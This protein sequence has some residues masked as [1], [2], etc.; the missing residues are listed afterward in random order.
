[1]VFYSTSYVISF[2]GL[3]LCIYFISWVHNA[4]LRI[5]Q[6]MALKTPEFVSCCL[7]LVLPLFSFRAEISIFNGKISKFLPY[8]MAC[9]TVLL[10]LP[11]LKKISKIITQRRLWLNI[12]MTLGQTMKGKLS[13]TVP[14]YIAL[15]QWKTPLEN[16]VIRPLMRPGVEMFWLVRFSILAK[17]N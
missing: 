14:L 3:Y 12:A 5:H 8:S 13:V 10:L 11:I 2:D 17:R 16:E 4:F 1:M 15:L 7:G 6:G 9:R